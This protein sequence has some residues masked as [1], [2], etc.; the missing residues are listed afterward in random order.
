MIHAPSLKVRH[1]ENKEPV[2]LLPAWLKARRVLTAGARKLRGVIVFYLG[3]GIAVKAEKQHARS[4][5]HSE[6]V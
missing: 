1:W 3:V 6:P 2:S 4:M 5:R